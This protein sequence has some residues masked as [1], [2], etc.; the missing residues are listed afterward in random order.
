M[1][2]SACGYISKTIAESNSKKIKATENDQ[3][4]AD[5]GNLATGKTSITTGNGNL[6]TSGN[7]VLTEN[8]SICISNTCG[9]V[10]LQINVDVCL[11]YHPLWGQIVVRNGSNTSIFGE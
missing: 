2:L 3:I 7:M 4:A 9:I 11:E 1:K 10:D 6:A 8:Y 5:E